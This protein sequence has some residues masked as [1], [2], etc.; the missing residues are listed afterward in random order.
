MDNN[1][2]RTIDNFNTAKSKATTFAKKNLNKHRII[3]IT[4]ILFA[5]L[6]LGLFDFVKVEFRW[7]NLINVDYWVSVGIKA[8][9]STS[10][11]LSMSREMVMN[12]ITNDNEYLNRKKDVDTISLMHR[13]DELNKYLANYNREVKINVYKY[14]V[15][16]QIGEL[17]KDA[18][19]EDQQAWLKY[20]KSLKNGVVIEPTN[21]YCL[22]RIYL[23]DTLKDEYIQEN[24]DNLQVKFDTTYAD[25]LTTGREELGIGKSPMKIKIEVSRTKKIGWRLMQMVAF[26]AL[27]GA[28][29]KDLQDNYK[30]LPIIASVLFAFFLVV[31][32]VVMG[33]A[34]GKLE[35][36]SI[37]LPKMDFRFQRLKDYVRFERIE[38]KWDVKEQKAIE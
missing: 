31:M 1:I 12:L 10:I 5:L 25:E 27:W 29:L 3:N 7:E 2:T 13:G 17:D 34:D 28:L 11:Y 26:A 6:L 19:F 35:Y 36:D 20:A 32:A 30:V 38:N 18:Q 9:A 4:L 8:I 15:N 14:Q 22:K 16:R 24:I 23:M 21:E 33:L 37:E